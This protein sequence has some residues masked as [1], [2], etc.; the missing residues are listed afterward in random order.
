MRNL[1]KSLLATAV[2]SAVL[3]YG[4]SLLTGLPTPPLLAQ[5]D[6]RPVTASEAQAQAMKG[7]AAARKLRPS[8]PDELPDFELL[9]ASDPA[10]RGEWDGKK[11]TIFWHGKRTEL[12]FLDDTAAHENGH[13]A[14]QQVLEGALGKAKAA[15]AWALLDEPDGTGLAAAVRLWPRLADVATAY[16]E[17]PGKHGTY[18]SQNPDE[19]LAE[20]FR[21]A[22][23]GPDAATGWEQPDPSVVALLG[24]TKH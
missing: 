24:G 2:A 20:G 14:V 9:P 11:A 6:P 5:L 3:Y 12:D 13:R 4:L 17:D 15:K 21:F 19:W 18:G 23:L 16:R 22:A 1:L 10:L 8:L 7:V